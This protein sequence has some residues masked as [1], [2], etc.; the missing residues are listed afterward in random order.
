MSRNIQINDQPMPWITLTSDDVLSEFTP[1]EAASI[2]NMQGSGSGSGPPFTNIDIITARTIDEV[3]GFILA[4]DYAIDETADDTL[5]K[6]LFA[7][8]IAIARWR[9]LIAAPQLRQFR[10]KSERKRLTMPWRSSTR[11][12]IRSLMLSRRC[13]RL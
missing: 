5:P 13:R 11:S 3:R 7:D 8:A 2:R 10:L 6:G 4:G 9:T 1:N 12:R